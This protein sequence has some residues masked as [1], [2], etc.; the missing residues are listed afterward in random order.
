MGA[1]TNGGSSDVAAQR[2]AFRRELLAAGYLIDTGVRGVF[3]RGRAFQA[4]IRSLERLL[5]GPCSDGGAERVSFPPLTPR[6]VLQRAGFLENF[7]TLCGWV[8]AFEGDERAHR[9]LLERAGAGEDWSDALRPTE[10]ALTPAACY[11]L[12]P[13]LRGPLPAQGRL[14]DFTAYCFRR[15]PSD[16]PARMQAFQVRENVR[17]GA[18]EAVRAWRQ[19]WVARAPEIAASLGLPARIAPAHDPFFGRAGRLLA[20]NQLE[21]ELKFELLVPIWSDE[22]PTAVASFNYHVDHFSKA[23]EIRLPDGTDA[24][25]AC[26]GF[27]L[28]RIAI[29]LFRVHGLDL[30]RWP[31]AVRGQLDS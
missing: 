14:F 30:E 10:F 24:H 18:P 22:S 28:D 21:L 8:H 23:F 1:V 4:V 2:D 19:G 13:T 25:S 15:E 5:D 11:P 26:L 7:P 29:A 20:S 16:D 3:G 6:H 12:Y 31:E 9:S 27:G 17:L